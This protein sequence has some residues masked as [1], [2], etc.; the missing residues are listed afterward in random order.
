[1]NMTHQ[2]RRAHL[3]EAAVILA[4]TVGLSHVSHETIADRCSVSHHLVRFHFAN[5][6]ILWSIIADHPKA[7]QD[8]RNEAVLIGVK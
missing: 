4:N 3:T 8:V 5:K 2:A 6:R 7:S 1:M